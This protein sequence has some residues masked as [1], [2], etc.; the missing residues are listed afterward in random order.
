MLL[1][2]FFVLYIGRPYYRP[3]SRWWKLLYIPAFVIVAGIVTN[4]FH[5]IAF[6]FTGKFP[7]WN[8]AYY[9]HGPLYLAVLLWMTILFAAMLAV[10]FIRCAVP[11]RR[12][13]IWIPMIP[14]GI[15]IAYLILF[16]VK[17]DSIL[18]SMFKVPEIG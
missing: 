4:D 10:D 16:F 12:R 14:L 5:Q 11:A 15:G 18:L 2:F 13:K 7:A 17:P 9:R 8:D 3:I 1:L 6:R